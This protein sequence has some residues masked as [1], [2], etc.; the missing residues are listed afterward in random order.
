MFCSGSCTRVYCNLYQYPN[1]LSESVH[2]VPA[3]P[4][5]HSTDITPAKQKRHLHRRPRCSVG[6]K[7]FGATSCRAL[8]PEPGALRTTQCNHRYRGPSLMLKSPVC[9]AAI[10]YSPRVYCSG[11]DLVHPLLRVHALRSY[12]TCYFTDRISTVIIDGLRRPY[13]SVAIRIQSAHS[14]V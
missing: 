4:Y 12:C 8:R 14:R 11:A 9:V 10:R 13:R 6:P 7:P 2:Q 3:S 1:P 5:P